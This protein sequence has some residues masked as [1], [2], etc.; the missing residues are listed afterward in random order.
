MDEIAS[1]PFILMRLEILMREIYLYPLLLIES[2]LGSWRII[3]RLFQY[4]FCANFMNVI[5]KSVE[6]QYHPCF[7]IPFRA[8]IV[9]FIICKKVYLAGRIS[10]NDS[11]AWAFSFEGVCQD[12]DLQNYLLSLSQHFFSLSCKYFKFCCS[13]KILFCI[14]TGQG[15]LCTKSSFC[16]WWKNKAFELPSGTGRIASQIFEVQVFLQHLSIYIIQSIVT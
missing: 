10:G 12:F 5:L 14:L 15:I 11:F 8:T 7:H 1:Q 4:L 6:P 16:S 13:I 9:D 2:V 3:E